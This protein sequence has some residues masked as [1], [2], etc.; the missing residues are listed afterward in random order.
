L[1]GLLEQA[2]RHLESSDLRSASAKLERACNRAAS[3]WGADES[4]GLAGSRTPQMR[5]ADAGPASGGSETARR[6]PRARET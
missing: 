6:L 3:L 2:V 5:R 1:C 4:P